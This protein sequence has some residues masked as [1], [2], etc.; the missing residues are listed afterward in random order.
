MPYVTIT[1][2]LLAYNRHE[3]ETVTFNADDMAESL[4]GAVDL[5]RRRCSSSGLDENAEVDKVTVD[6]SPI[7]IDSYVSLLSVIHNQSK[8]GFYLERGGVSF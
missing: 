8:L 6:D 4:I 2:H 3:N 1:H 7:I 5:A